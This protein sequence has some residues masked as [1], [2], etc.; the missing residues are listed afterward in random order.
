M[1]TQDF[2]CEKER[3]FP[4]TKHYDDVNYFESMTDYNK[5]SIEWVNA[6]CKEN[7]FWC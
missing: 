2:K 4:K 3:L 5:I 1:T 6:K 7:V